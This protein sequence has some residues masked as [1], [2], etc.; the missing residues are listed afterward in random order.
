M[1]NRKI[2]AE[3]IISKVSALIKTC[4]SVLPKDVY[5]DI[6]LCK[7]KTSNEQEKRFLEIIILTKNRINH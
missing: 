3:Q 2:K 5:D 1:A 6:T 7:E 4:N